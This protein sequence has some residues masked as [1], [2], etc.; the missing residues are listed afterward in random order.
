MKTRL[1]ALCL[2]LVL[3]FTMATGGLAGCIVPYCRKDF[4]YDESLLLRGMELIY[5][6]NCEK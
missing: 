4:I 3:I 6:L 1:R 2:A 5:R